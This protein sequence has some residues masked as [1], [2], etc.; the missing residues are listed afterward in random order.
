MTILFQIQ[1]VFQKF[2]LNNDV[3]Q[4]IFFKIFSYYQNIIK[5]KWNF[6]FINKNLLIHRIS[7]YNLI[8]QVGYV[9][10]NVFDKNIAIDFYRASKI[11]NNKSDIQIFYS[12]F[13][14]LR[15]FYIFQKR[16]WN[17]INYDT[18]CPFYKMCK[19]SLKIFYK[20]YCYLII[21]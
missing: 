7:C 5:N 14:Y 18:S 16:P 2:N 12:F 6:H 15:D 17:K 4:I 19:I 21:K 8:Q 1:T 3:Q 13:I 9:F 10:Y 11:I 20:K